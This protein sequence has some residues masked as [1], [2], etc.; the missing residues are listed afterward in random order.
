[1]KTL[2]SLLSLSALFVSHSATAGIV[3]LP[4][5]VAAVPVDSPWVIF[6]LVASVA[7]IGARI[8]HSRRK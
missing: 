5:A 6:G 3:A 7:V 8:L 4:P 2:V 1:M